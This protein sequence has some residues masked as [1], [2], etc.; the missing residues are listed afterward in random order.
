MSRP[1]LRALAP[2]LTRIVHDET[3]ACRRGSISAEH[4]IGQLRVGEM[5]R[6][7]HRIELELM[8]EL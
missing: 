5:P 3:K 4:G 7:R 8:R 2:G 6:T 1:I